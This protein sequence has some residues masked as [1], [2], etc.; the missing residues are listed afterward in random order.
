VQPG[1]AADREPMTTVRS[2]VRSSLSL[3]SLLDGDAVL[4]P[5]LAVGLIVGVASFAVGGPGGEL[6]VD[7]ALAS[8]VTFLFGVLLAFTIARAR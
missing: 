5:S 2:T 7:V 4:W 3:R 6:A 8:M 1:T